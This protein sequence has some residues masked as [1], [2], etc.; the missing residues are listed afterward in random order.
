M[1]VSEPIQQLFNQFQSNP[2]ASWWQNLSP[3]YEDILFLMNIKGWTKLSAE[4]WIIYCDYNVLQPV[5]NW[6][7]D[8]SSPLK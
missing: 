6:I 2:Q 3:Q 8:V 7:A 1:W 5:V 4:A